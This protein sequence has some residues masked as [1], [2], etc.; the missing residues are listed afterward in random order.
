ML[1]AAIRIDARLKTDVRAV[2][3]IDDARRPVVVELRPRQ[4]IIVRIPFR[5]RFE[6]DLLKPVRRIFRRPAMR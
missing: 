5:I 1:A 6:M 2:V 4:R 3:A